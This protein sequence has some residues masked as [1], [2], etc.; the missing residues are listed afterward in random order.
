LHVAVPVIVTP[1]VPRVH[2]D[3]L[4]E[5]PRKTQRFTDASYVVPA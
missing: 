1:P 5:R 3:A 4:E 2:V